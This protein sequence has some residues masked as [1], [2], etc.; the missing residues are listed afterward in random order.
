MTRVC[1]ARGATDDVYVGVTTDNMLWLIFVGLACLI[2]AIT[3]YS[4]R[5]V[6]TLKKVRKLLEEEVDSL[7]NKVRCGVSIPRP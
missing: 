5:Y 4:V 7:Q 2:I 3:A 6:R 1:S